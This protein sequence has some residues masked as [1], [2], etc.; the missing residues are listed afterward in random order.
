MQN[1]VV[2]FIFNKHLKEWIM[3]IA[4][5]KTTCTMDCPDTCTLDVAVENNKIVKID[6]NKDNPVTN[7]FICSKV[8]KFAERVYHKDRVLFPM[9]LLLNY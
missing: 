5:I 7:G 8:S 9:K 4:T 1:D 6:G 2:F 3:S